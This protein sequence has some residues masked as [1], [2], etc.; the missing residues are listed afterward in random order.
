MYLFFCKKKKKS[1]KKQ[2]NLLHSLNFFFSST[3]PCD[4]EIDLQRSARDQ[5]V[6]VTCT[7]AWLLFIEQIE[8]DILIKGLLMTDRWCLRLRVIAMVNH[9]MQIA[10]NHYQYLCLSSINNSSCSFTFLIQLT[11]FVNMTSKIRKSAESRWMR[12]YLTIFHIAFRHLNCL[13]YFI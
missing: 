5:L 3:I 9:W 7:T 6:S 10:Q 4:T 11:C 13:P 12:Y 1:V 2:N 8:T